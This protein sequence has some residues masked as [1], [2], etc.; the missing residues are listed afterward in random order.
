MTT[1]ISRPL[2][3]PRRNLLSFLRRTLRGYINRFFDESDTATSD[4]TAAS[5]GQTH[6]DDPN[7]AQAKCP[8]D[9]V[10]WVNTRS[11]VFHMPGTRWFGMTE[12][13][14]YECESDAVSEGDRESRNGQ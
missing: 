1:G 9:V 7:A 8:N 11:G 12:Y 6:F 10:V 14:T 3:H 4:S 13:G 2:P 5:S